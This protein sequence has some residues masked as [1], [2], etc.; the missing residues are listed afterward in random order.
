[1]LS[2]SARIACPRGISGM[3]LL[4]SGIQPN[5]DTGLPPLSHFQG[6][7]V[8]ALGRELLTGR[9][10]FHT[11]R[12]TGAGRFDRGRV[13]EATLQVCA[14]PDRDSRGASKDHA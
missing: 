4:P 5:R 3:P 14:A 11:D 10:T 7:G 9:E 8:A 12:E 1:M 2:V 6:D 13:P